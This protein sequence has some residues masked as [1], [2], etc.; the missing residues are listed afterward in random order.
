MGVPNASASYD[1]LSQ[2]FE[3]QKPVESK[4]KRTNNRL[5]L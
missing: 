5:R 2:R 1:D 4:P 3:A